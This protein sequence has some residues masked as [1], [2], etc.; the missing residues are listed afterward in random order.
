[1]TTRKQQ[2]HSKKLSVIALSASLL[3]LSTSLMAQTTSK[4]IIGLASDDGPEPIVSVYG[5]ADV[6]YA[7]VKHTLPFSAT[8]PAT[9][10]FNTQPTATIAPGTQGGVIYNDGTKAGY[11]LI[12]GGIQ[13]SRWGVRVGLDLGEG[14]KANL[15]LES[16]INLPDGSL[17]N[18]ATTITQNNSVSSS[19]NLTGAN[20]VNANSSL[21][22]QL[23]NRQAFLSVSDP[24][25]GTLGVGRQYNFIYDVLNEYDPVYFSQ[26]FSPLGLS[27][28]LGG[29]GG[30]SE[31]TRL[32]NS[33]KYTVK[34]GSV[35][36][37]L[38]Y[39]FGNTNTSDPTSGAILNFGYSDGAFGAQFVAEE[40][41]NA[42]KLT[43][44]GV[45]LFNSQSALF[46]AKYKFKNSLTIKGGYE[47]YTLAAPSTT[48]TN[49][50]G[51]VNYYGLTAINSAGTSA[52]YGSLLYLSDGIAQGKPNKQYS[53][54]FVGGDYNVTPKVNIAVGLYDLQTMDSNGAQA[55]GDIY[56]GSVVADFKVN[57]YFDF[58][59]G[60]SYANFT[61]AA[62]NVAAANSV[63]AGGKVAS[64]SNL[65]VSFG[66]RLK[67]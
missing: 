17:N 37:G 39:K 29:G 43:S 8:F 34:K 3:A 59:E 10:A 28:T 20:Q 23:F 60:I 7:F 16:G 57:K 19:T 61:G 24:A 42:M 40:F 66:M 5:V 27:G 46:S 15:V 14:A 51:G 49:Y 13:G 2:S 36:G 65:L 67:F 38:M 18:A 11:G 1:M 21:N 53:V 54:A 56:W 58:Y 33:V 4:P 62:Y 12:N 25:L 9:I 31:D 32:D 41:T 35:N 48:S 44:S 30:I 50:S 63:T 26:L 52:T 22:G 47:I 64:N 6:G 45:Q 55:K